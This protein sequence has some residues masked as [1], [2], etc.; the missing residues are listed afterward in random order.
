MRDDDLCAAVLTMP[1][2]AEAEVEKKSVGK[3][4]MGWMNTGQSRPWG[5]EVR[6]VGE[7]GAV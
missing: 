3:Y 6:I 2:E 1:A 7:K 5:R 4:E